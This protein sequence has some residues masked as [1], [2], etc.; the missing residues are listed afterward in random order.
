MC[1][2]FLNIGAYA[3]LRF[4]EIVIVHPCLDRTFDGFGVAPNGGTMPIEYLI[5]VAKRLNITTDKVPDIRILCH[6]TQCQL[7]PAPA[8]NIGRVGFLHGLWFTACIF[9][10]VV[11][12]I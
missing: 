8:Y 9:K 11:L 10:L 4:V 6:D 7:L 2:S 1:C 12:P 5:F 3:I